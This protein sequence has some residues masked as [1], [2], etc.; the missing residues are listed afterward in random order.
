MKLSRPWD[1]VFVVVLDSVGIGALPDAAAYGDERANTLAHIA[2]G[3]PG[4]RLPNLQRLGLGCIASLNGVPCTSQPLAFFGKMAEQSAGKDT[5]TGH[6]ELM[7]L[8]IDKPFH[9][10]PNGFPQ[11]LIHE[12]SAR[13]GRGVLGNKPA[14]GT[15]VLDEYG[16]QQL[17]GGE[18][19]VY[20]SADSVLQIAAHEDVIPLAELYRAC[21]FARELTM[22]EEWLVG[23]VI[24][25]P[26]IGT[27]GAFVRT[28]NR[29]DYAVPPPA[30]T[31]L[32][33]LQ[34]AGFDTVAIGKISDI[35]C[36]QGID[37]SYPTKSNRH[38]MEELLA[39]MGRSF[40]GLC[41]VNLVDFDSLYGH[42][43]D[44][45][46]YARALMAFD[47]QLGEVLAQL[48]ERDLLVLTADH[49]NDPT[50]PGTDHTREYVPL[51][52]VDGRQI[53]NR[54]SLSGA[55]NIVLGV[56]DSFADLSATIAD[57]FNVEF[58][59]HGVSFLSNITSFHS[60]CEGD[61]SQ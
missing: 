30:P 54:S 53:A 56:R 14:S 40:C 49:G 31:L 12:F 16:E 9:T 36:G 26:Y 17:S 55:G 37:Q 35:F 6:W 57:I 18:W 42:R 21:E 52:V 5:M 20:T 2:D 60:I 1:R 13:T 27:P 19:I 48:G 39:A 24:A 38:G 11:S 46:G 23:R 8:K 22:R 43:R 3:F 7:G 47:E 45:D 59:T 61:H 41:F 50:H 29:H 25:R 32:D 44:V 4:F 28:P 34:T 15:A 10:Y 51:L 58:A 33:R